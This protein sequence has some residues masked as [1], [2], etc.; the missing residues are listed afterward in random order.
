MTVRGD[1]RGGRNQEFALGAA[2][3]TNGNHGIAMVA[4]GTDG[5]GRL[6]GCG[7]SHHRWLHR[8][9]GAESLGLSPEEILR[10]NDTFRFF[11]GLGDLVMTGPTGTNVN[12]IAVAADGSSRQSCLRRLPESPRSTFSGL[13]PFTTMSL[14]LFFA[15]LLDCDRVDYAVDS[16]RVISPRVSRRASG[17]RPWAA[18][19][20]SCAGA[21]PPCRFLPG[22]RP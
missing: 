15:I 6:Y 10:Q 4:L 11:E 13:F 7:R 20:P 16:G 2:M 21:G 8:S 14:I 5:A 18:A 9:E 3:K 12:D 17:T 22:R 19:G 1:G